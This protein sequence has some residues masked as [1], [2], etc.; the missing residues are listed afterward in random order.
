[1]NRPK[2]TLNNP[3]NVAFLKIFKHNLI[4]GLVLSRNFEPN[5][6][7]SRGGKLPFKFDYSL[8]LVQDH[9]PL[10]REWTDIGTDIVNKHLKYQKTLRRYKEKVSC[11]KSKYIV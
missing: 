1:M 7:K 5:L 11:N 6:F 4:P 3:I 10:S 2:K 8:P 9:I